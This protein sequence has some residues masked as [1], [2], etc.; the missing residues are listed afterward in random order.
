MQKK[1][2]IKLSKIQG[3]MFVSKTI[4]NK[5]CTTNQ[6]IKKEKKEKEQKT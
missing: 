6:K 2:K 4:H 3:F 1:T 5:P